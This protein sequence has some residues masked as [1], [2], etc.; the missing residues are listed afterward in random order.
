MTDPFPPPR[1]PDRPTDAELVAAHLRG[2][3]GALAG[4]YDRYAASLYDTAAVMLGDRDEA[5]D[6]TQDVFVVCARQLGQL[7]EPDRLKPWMFAILRNEV[8]R[9]TKQR[10]RAR[11]TDFAAPEGPEVAGLPDPSAEGGRAEAAELGA[12]VRSAA[13]G[14]DERDQL[15]LELSAR[16]GLEGADLAAALGVSTSQSYVMV[17]RMR[18]RIERSLGALLVARMGR[19]DCP[20]LAALLSGWDGTFSVLIR[21]RVARHVDDCDVCDRSRKKY[22]VVPLL[23]AAPAI[24]LPLDLRGTVLDGIAGAMVA[25]TPLD[26]PWAPPTQTLGPTPTDPPVKAPRRQSYEPP[27]QFEA[28]GGFPSPIGRGGLTKLAVIIGSIAATLVV[29]GGVA[30]M[31]GGDDG[32]VADATT[33]VSVPDVVSP[34]LDTSPATTVVVPATVAPTVAPVTTPTT[35]AET[36]APTTVPETIV[37]T[38]APET[39]VAPEPP[40]SVGSIPGGTVAPK[41]VPPTAPPPLPPPPST[42]PPTTA[43]PTPGNLVLSTQSV[44]LGSDGTSATLTLTNIGQQALD[45]AIG[46]NGSAAPIAVTPNSGPLAPGASVQVQVTIDR[47]GQPEGDVARSF[48]A[49]SSATGGGQFSVS[50]RVEIAPSVSLSGPTTA[51]GCTAPFRATVTDT[52]PISSVVLSWSGPGAPGSVSMNRDGADWFGSMTANATGTWTVTATATDARGNV[53]TASRSVNLARCG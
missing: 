41:V 53:G 9:R 38:T 7:R 10:G 36:I 2:E 46:A 4:I 12:L 48:V 50:A 20:D 26:P 29:V 17:H 43:A 8:Y 44:Q 51:A 3:R 27:Y 52:S 6:A 33:P 40:T 25:P 42:T 35:V 15:V 11:P 13:A 31:D 5:A 21:K 49:T 47:T 28:D 23:G 32:A 14:L 18:E 24:A 39:T 1:V 37:P 19:R 30:L 22:A 45:W 16:Q 34:P